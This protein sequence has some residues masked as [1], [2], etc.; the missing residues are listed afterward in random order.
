MSACPRIYICASLPS[1]SSRRLFKQAPL[2]C[3]LHVYFY[4]ST[5]IEHPEFPHSSESLP[6]KMHCWRPSLDAPVAPKRTA[7]PDPS[8]S[9]LSNVSS[10]S[11]ARGTLQ[12][13]NAQWLILHSS[14]LAVPRKRNKLEDSKLWGCSREEQ[15][16]PRM[17]SWQQVNKSNAAEFSSQLMG[18][19][20]AV[21]KGCHP[22]GRRPHR[23]A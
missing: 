8:P 11:D 14:A 18:A 3:A 19:L 17:Q 23:L 12:H 16:K 6:Q 7:A 13:S 21:R 9:G 20:E 22:P 2:K 4:P 1:V 15:V 5:I 10:V